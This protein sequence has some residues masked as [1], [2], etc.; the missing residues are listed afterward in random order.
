MAMQ[1]PILGW[2]LGTFPVVYPQFRTFYTNFYVNEARNDYLQTLAETGAAGFLTALW[3][4]VLLYRNALR[5]LENWPNEINGSIALACLLG[6]TGI[7]V[8]SFVD[9][10]LQIPANSPWFYVL[11]VLAASPYA[12]ETRQRVRLM[13]S[14][15]E[16]DSPVSQ[17]APEGTI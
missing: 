16:T 15:N 11:A 2:G 10:N 3:F 8:H 4:I 7:L 1:R 17:T 5:K 14:R 13:R 6:C 9:F 12:V